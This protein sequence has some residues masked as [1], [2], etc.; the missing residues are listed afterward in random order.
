MADTQE[1]QRLPLVQNLMNRS[2]SMPDTDK[3]IFFKI[4]WLTKPPSHKDAKS[5]K[6]N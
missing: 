4:S 5:E 1:P 6:K 3:A 2:F